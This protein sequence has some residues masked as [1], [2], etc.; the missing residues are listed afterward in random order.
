MVLQAQEVLEAAHGN[1]VQVQANAHQVFSKVVDRRARVAQTQ[2]TLTKACDGLREAEGVLECAKAQVFGKTL[3]HVEA[4]S[5]HDKAERLRTLRAAAEAESLRRAEAESARRAEAEAESARKAAVEAERARWAA[6]ERAERAQQAGGAERLHKAAAAGW[7]RAPEALGP[8]PTQFAWRA[9]RKWVEAEQ[10]TSQ[11][12]ADGAEPEAAQQEAA[13]NSTQ[14]KQRAAQAFVNTVKRRCL[15]WEFDAFV[16]VLHEFQ[17]E[18]LPPPEMLARMATVFQC[19]LDVLD[20]F[21]QLAF[22]RRME[23]Q[24]QSSNSEQDAPDVTAA[25]SADLEAVVVPEDTARAEAAATAPENVEANAPTA[26]GA[27]LISRRG[28]RI[29]ST[30]GPAADAPPADDAPPQAAD[31]PLIFRK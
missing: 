1:L 3:A 13:A 25:D 14:E 24:K 31:A 18:A 8:T 29:K 2:T 19:H 15:R 22:V 5:A 9:L 17:N 28:F 10:S 20:E 7:P 12:T 4:K 30:G 16:Q 26:A 6:A 11:L 27:P 21:R 23:P